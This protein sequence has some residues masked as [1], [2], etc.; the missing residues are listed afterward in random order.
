M[1]VAPPG[2]GNIGD[3]AMVEAYLEAAEGVV[4]IVTSGAGSVLVPDAHR[5]RTEL[6]DLPGLLYGGGETRAAALD[7][8]GQ[9]LGRSRSLSVIGADIMDG[10]YNPRASVMR[11]VVAEAA[12]RLGVETRV[13]G[14]SWSGRPHRAAR[15]Q[16]AA[17]SRAGALLFPRDPV[18]A[19]RLESDGIGYSK[20]VADI[21]FTTTSRDPA[22]RER[23]RIRGRYAVVNVS[24]H[25]DR[26][27]KLADDYVRIVEWLREQ[28]LEVVLLPHVV[29]ES[30]DDRV[31]CGEVAAHFLDGVHLVTETAT[32][33]QVRG[34]TERAA[35][36]VT[37]RMHLAIMSVMFGVPAVTLAS[38]GKV[39]GMMQLIGTPEM[40]VTPIAGIADTVIPLMAASLPDDSRQRASISASAPHVRD[41]ASQNFAP[42]SQVVEVPK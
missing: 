32:P 40:C 3:Q 15:A 14:F 37:G 41:L 21:V 18:S 10:F 6:V 1:L 20:A 30:A 26:G 36:T 34:L 23:L 8:F 12:A 25:L 24:G 22:L 42:K 38:Q 19:E 11:G 5:D 29:T 13:L 35:L 31:P 33:A 27:V 28:D 16:L 7:R 39:E 17:A 2:G 9:L 4:V